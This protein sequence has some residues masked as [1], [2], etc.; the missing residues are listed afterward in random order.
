MAETKGRQ[1]RLTAE[2]L[3]KVKDLR[4]QWRVGAA[5]EAVEGLSTAFKG[6]QGPKNLPFTGRILQPDGGSAEGLTVWLE[7]QGG[8]LVAGPVTTGSLGEFRFEAASGSRTLVVHGATGNVRLPADTT[9]LVGGGSFS[10]P[11]PLEPVPVTNPEEQGHVS[12][13]EGDCGRAFQ[14]YR[15]SL[16]RFRFGC[17]VRLASAS[18]WPL[19]MDG[20]LGGAGGRLGGLLRGLSFRARTALG[21]PIDVASY[22]DDLAEAP[23]SVPR[24]ATLGLGY[25][26]RF[27]QQ[28]TPTGLSLGELL[29]S[30]PLAPGESHRIVTR[31]QESRLAVRDETHRSEVMSD[32]AE[33]VT[34]SSTVEV[35]RQA[36]RETQRSSRSFESNSDAWE[37]GGGFSLF[38]LIAASGGGGGS[39][40]S[41]NAS[42]TQSTARDLVLSASRDFHG[43]LHAV[44]GF[45][46][47][48]NRTDIRSARA[49]E[50]THGTI[51]TVTNH[52]RT[53]A[54][55]MQWWQV[56]RNFEVQTD[57]ED[58]QLCVHVPLELV[59]W[60]PPGVSATLGS[61]PATRS[62]LLARY[63]SLLR[64]AEV[65][66]RHVSHDPA[67]RQGLERLLE[68]AAN[69]NLRPQTVDPEAEAEE[70]GLRIA[71]DAS[72][73]P[74]DR[75]TVTL[76][77]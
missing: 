37:V 73:L 19:R 38:G 3:R 6:R 75:A 15:G 16:D 65:I 40:T 34:D 77:A 72:W 18:L 50:Q 39:S 63:T 17:H 33:T 68:L 32:F 46:R 62:D 47:K 26:V 67:R 55:T 53:R 7:N 70:I 76:V 25:V 71:V 27:V 29:H 52:N 60:L 42:G 22:L 54:L 35:F 44:A 66:R 8:D 10:L 36:L 23:K 9:G 56:L 49:G 69:P 31:D 30:L 1:V 28:W 74:V 24:A 48:A 13:G 64:H 41:G 21:A 45:S 20:K 58:I 51:R 4:Q 2:N 57:I 43:H 12:L 5:I 14:S 61:V 11:R 59:A